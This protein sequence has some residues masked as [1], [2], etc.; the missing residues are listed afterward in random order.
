MSSDTTAT[1]ILLWVQQRLQTQLNLLDSQ[2]F[3][4]A[5]NL[6][7]PKAPPTDVFLTISP[8]GGQFHLPEA[9]PGNLLERWTF[10]VRIFCRVLLDRA[11]HD[12][13]RLVDQTRGLLRWKQMV[14]AALT[15][16]ENPEWNLRGWIAPVAATEPQWLQGGRNA[17]LNY[18][19]LAI[20]FQAD[21]DWQWTSPP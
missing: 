16:L 14:L 15:G 9:A 21:F 17:E 10:R 19:S 5:D 13:H 18:L 4:T 8:G 12:Q 6:S 1:D 11:D 7:P 3:L 2:C 20:D